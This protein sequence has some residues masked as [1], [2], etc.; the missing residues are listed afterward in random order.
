MTPRLLPL[1]ALASALAAA[2]AHQDDTRGGITT[3]RSGSPEGARVTNLAPDDPAERLAIELCRRAES[4]GKTG[5]RETRW[6]TETACV[7]EVERDVPARVRSWSCSPAR[8]RLEECLAAIRSARCEAPVDGRW[9]ELAAC[10]AEVV[11]AA[12]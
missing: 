11:C 10:R 9:P 7:A 5:R 4:C 2:C 3:I 12:P 1:L 6:P 8:G